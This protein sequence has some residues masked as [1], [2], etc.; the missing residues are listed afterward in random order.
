M[1]PSRS[2][3]DCSGFSQHEQSIILHALS[4]HA[5]LNNRLTSTTRRP[6]RG[7]P[8]ERRWLQVVGEALKLKDLQGKKIDFGILHLVIA[9]GAFGFKTIASSEGHINRARAVPW[10][11]LVLDQSAQVHLRRLLSKFYRGRPVPHDLRF[12]LLPSRRSSTFRLAP[13]AF[14]QQ[15]PFQILNAT[16]HFSAVAGRHRTLPLFSRTSTLQQLNPHEIAASGGHSVS[17]VDLCPPAGRRCFPS[18]PREVPDCDH[19][20]MVG[21]QPGDAEAERYFQLFR[22]AVAGS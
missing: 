10:V 13:A 21:G 8:V 18:C 20:A 15:Q 9:L 5:Q 7:P 16:Q 14:E 11:D 1:K 12:I 17:E 22:H 4:M 19:V 3:W 6:F 2:A